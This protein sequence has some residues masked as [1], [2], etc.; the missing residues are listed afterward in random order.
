MAT[1]STVNKPYNLLLDMF[2]SP[3]MNIERP[4]LAGQFLRKHHLLFMEK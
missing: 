1:I 2:S 3:F 4:T